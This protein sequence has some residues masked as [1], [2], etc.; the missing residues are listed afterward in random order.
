MIQPYGDR[1]LVKI[2]N[3]DVEEGPGGF[4]KAE[5]AR[6]DKPLKGEIISLGRSNVLSTVS[7]AVL[8]EG[9]IIYFASYGYDEIGEFIIV[10]FD[11]ILG[12]ER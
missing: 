9:D 5:G 10:P 12:V 11:L 8:K 3:D 1:V 4:V 6:K 2:K 7:N